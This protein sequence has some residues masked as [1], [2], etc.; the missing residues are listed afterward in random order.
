MNKDQHNQDRPINLVVA[1]EIAAGHIDDDL[2][3]MFEVRI[4]VQLPVSENLSGGL[5]TWNSQPSQ[6]KCFDNYEKQARIANFKEKKYYDL[7]EE[8]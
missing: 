6:M 2:L 5:R 8:W 1:R 4:C 7:T 3:F